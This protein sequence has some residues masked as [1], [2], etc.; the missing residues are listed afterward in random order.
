MRFCDSSLRRTMASMAS[1]D[2][3]S[4]PMRWKICCRISWGSA[5]N[6]TSSSWF[7]WLRIRWERW[8][9]FSRESFMGEA[10]ARSQDDPLLLGQLALHH[11][12]HL[13]VGDVRALHLFR[14]L[15]QDLAHFVVEAVLHLQVLGD[16]AA[17]DLGHAGLGVDLQLALAHQRL[18]DLARDEFNLV[19]GEAHARSIAAS[20]ARSRAGRAARACYPARAMPLHVIEHPLLDDTMARLRDRATPSDEF[21]RLAR[22][23]SLL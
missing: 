20:C 23:V 4:S 17:E 12:E 3:I 19:R 9:I 6:S 7:R 16:D 11:L 21:R 18:H 2:F 13:A 1:S 8:T 14:V 22:R 15:D 10:S 5:K